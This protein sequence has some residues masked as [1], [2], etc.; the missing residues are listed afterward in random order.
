MPFQN[1]VNIKQAL[2]QPGDFYDAAPRRVTVYKL[3]GIDRT[4]PCVGRVFTLDASGEP[5][6]G[7]VGAFAGL[8]VN[9]KSLANQGMDGQAASQG[10]NAELADMG[11]VIVTTSGPALPGQ[12]VLYDTATGEIVGTGSPSGGQ[13]AIPGATFAVF[14]AY[15]GGVAVVQL[16]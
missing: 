5:Q 1:T 2:G 4:T 16:G 8:L 13:A 15:A 14:A 7:G 9:P 6:L 12:A 11:R 3:T 10:I